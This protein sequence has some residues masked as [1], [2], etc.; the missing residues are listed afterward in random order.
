MLSPFHNYDIYIPEVINSLT[1]HKPYVPEENAAD[2]C[3]CMTDTSALD[4]E[5][6]I[7][8]VLIDMPRTLN[9][10]CANKLQGKRIL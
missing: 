8:C 1:L 5:A 4:Y 9:S 10:D 7:R 6:S 2:M 3:I